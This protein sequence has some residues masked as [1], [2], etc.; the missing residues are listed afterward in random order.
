VNGSAARSVNSPARFQQKRS[1]V[2]ISLRQ[3]PEC[4][5]SS[6]DFRRLAAILWRGQSEKLAMLSAKPKIPNCFM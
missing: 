6:L 3:T 5:G 4:C 1:F 2:E